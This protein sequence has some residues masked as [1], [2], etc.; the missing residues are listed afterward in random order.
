M[1]D[2][3]EIPLNDL[4][5]L[6]ILFQ[7]HIFIPQTIAHETEGLADNYIGPDVIEFLFE[8]YEQFDITNVVFGQHH[9]SF[10]VRSRSSFLFRPSKHTKLF[11]ALFANY[12]SK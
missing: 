2:E 8:K 9:Q 11:I 4:P 1:L 6:L 5:L 12:L 7:A 3:L 10:D